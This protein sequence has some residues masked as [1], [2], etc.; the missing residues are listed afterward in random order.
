MLRA[1]AEAHA[2]PYAIGE[3][4]RHDAV[5]AVQE[6][7]ELVARPHPARHQRGIQARPRGGVMTAPTVKI[8]LRLFWELAKGARSKAP[9]AELRRQFL[10]RA[11]TSGLISAAHSLSRHG[12]EDVE[13]VMDWALRGLDP[14]GTGEFRK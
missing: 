5:D 2:R 11:R 6:C 4:D 14:W 9:D 10:E 12:Q 13:H 8:R 1:E 3:L 7:A